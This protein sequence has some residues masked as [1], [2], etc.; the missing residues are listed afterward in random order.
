MS[1]T[2]EQL[3]GMFDDFEERMQAILDAES[4]GEEVDGQD[5]TD[6]LYEFGYGAD[7]KIV[8]TL[9]LAGGG[10]SAWIECECS[11]DQY[12]NLELDRAVYHATWWGDT[13]QHRTLDGS[14]ALYQYAERMIEGMEA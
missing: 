9:T 7:R 5:A 1:S 6:A 8:V 14:D 13:P 12:G 3:N 2:Q 10:P 11:A 4:A